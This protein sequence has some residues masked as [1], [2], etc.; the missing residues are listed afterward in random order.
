[1]EPKDAV[2]VVSIND[3]EPSIPKETRGVRITLD[4]GRIVVHDL[5]GHELGA[6]PDPGAPTKQ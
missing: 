5:A 1:V 6:L 3:K 4:H 2:D